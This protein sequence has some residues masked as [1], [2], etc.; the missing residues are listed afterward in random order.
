MTHSSIESPP[1]PQ[2]HD[3]HTGLYE[4]ELKKFN[5]SLLALEIILFAIGI[6]NLSSAT[7]VQDK[8][9]GLYKSQALWFGIGMCLTAVILVFHYSVLSRM[10]YVIY[11]T[12]I[13][14]LGGVL[15]LGKSSLGAKRWLGVGAFRMQPSEFMKLSMAIC[16]A[17][18]FESDQTVG[19][20]GFR[21]LIL[22]FLLVALPCGLIMLQPDLGTALIIL[23][24]FTSMMLFIRIQPRTLLA[25]LICGIIALPTAYRFALKPYQ[26]QRIIS[27]VNPGSDPKGSGYN[28][29]QSMIAV[30]SG[31]LLGKG[32]RK[33]TQSQLNFLPEH[34][35]DFIF[36]VFSEE[37]GF[38]GCMVLITLYLI[39]MMNGL[40]VAYQSHDKFGI[41]LALGIMTT[42]F[43]HIFVNMGMVMGLLP[44]VGVPLPFLSYGGS[45]LVTSILSVAILTN[46]ANKKFMF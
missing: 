3:R 41:L 8:S 10:A 36:S 26:K 2:D 13:L 31:Q 27:F 23:L 14:L 21:D 11:F 32:Y 1:L 40:S 12:N 6:W 16:M 43:W 42:F 17:K 29:I 15:F 45:S 24:S 34:H 33:G 35:T 18:Y 30:G 22:P 37:H 9:L 39:F 25:I 38:V 7:G 46:I 44:I 5:W 4:E 20:Y 28:S 19:G